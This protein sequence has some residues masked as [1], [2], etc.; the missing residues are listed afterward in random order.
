MAMANL[1]YSIIALEKGETQPALTYAKDS[2]KIMFH[3]WNKHEKK[4]KTAAPSTNQSGLADSLG[5][6]VS[7][8]DTTM[9]ARIVQGSDFWALTSPLIRALLRLSA[10]YAHM[11]MFQDT[12]YYA[13]QACKVAESSGSSLY[14]A[15]SAVWAGSVW[16]KGGKPDKGLDYVASARVFVTENPHSSQSVTLACQL[17]ELYRII[18]DSESEEK[19]LQLAEASVKHASGAGTA[20]QLDDEIASQMENLTLTEKTRTTRGTRSKA[21]TTKKASATATKRAPARS[22]ALA[23]PKPA[24]VLDDARTSLMRASI[25]LY[26]ALGHIHQKDW[27]SASGVLE[28]IKGRLKGLEDV[29]RE[30]MIRAACLVGQSLDD[31]IHDPVF[32]VVQESTISFPSV[33][34]VKRADEKAS[35]AKS[36]PARRGA[37]ARAATNF[38]DALKEA[39]E[40]LLNANSAAVIRGDG[41]SLHRISSLLQST[42]IF[43]SATKSDSI[44]HP[45]YA[46]CAVE[47]ARNVTWRRERKALQVIGSAAKMEW[48]APL[49]SLDSNRSS[50][51]AATD[52][53]RFQ[54]DYIDIIPSSWTVVSVSPSDNREDLCITRLQAGHTPF[55][56]RLPLERANSRDADNE[57]FSFHHGMEELRELIRLANKNSHDARDMTIKGAKAAWWEEREMLDERFK[58]LLD[59]IESVWLG[60]FKGVFSQHKR[61]TDLLAKFQKSFQNMLDKHLPS[62]RQIR[63]KRSAKTP[64]ITFDPRILELFIGLG[65]PVGDD[66]DYEEALTDLL[67]FTID[68]LQFHGEQN[69]YDEIDFDSMIVDTVDALAAYHQAANAGGERDDNAHTILVLDKSLH[70]FPWESLPCMQGAAVSRV[71]SLA[72]LR[73]LILE[74]RSSNLD[75][76]NLDSETPAIETGSRPGH[77]VSPS[78]GTYILNPGGDLSNTLSAFQKPLED[79]G[80]SWA[81]IVSRTPTEP[82]FERALS[83]SD[84]LLYFG[85][86]SGA[87]YIRGKTVRRMDKCRAAVLLMGCSSASLEAAGEFECHG[88]VWNYMLSGA[89]AVVGALWDVTD[90]EADRFAGKVFEEWGLMKTGTFKEDQKGKGRATAQKSDDDGQFREG[91]SLVE[92]VAKAR[93]ACRFKYLTSAAMCVYG[94]PVYINREG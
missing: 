85:H 93:D 81:G 13:E 77:H 94:I 92:A 49:A 73:R 32:S 46:T 14:I 8:L 44:G 51:G 39:Q 29:S 11:G 12:L 50:L 75:E 24:L 22:K 21:S 17:S 5:P 56:L 68:I 18:G 26:R 63:G 82:E 67:Y 1:L 37:K 86:G 2:V 72:C 9:V 58:M 48:P 23:P 20:P 36:A 66:L 15:Q 28:D 55:V 71:P 16:I 64:K 25:L 61:R 74:Q 87:Q 91:C 41:G 40:Y 47:L 27:A 65:G 4:D 70:A 33:S 79:L 90:R 10:L 57:I 78:S 89:P 69:A 3:D 19:M 42:V 31:M 53:S 54:R 45:G 52:I 76:M 30:Q 59:N 34:L 84:I 88:T 7:S 35:P 62:R 60:G 43:L 38:V 80:S 6:G 83:E